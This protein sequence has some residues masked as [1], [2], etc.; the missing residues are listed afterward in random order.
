MDAM[1]YCFACRVE[2]AYQS[3]RAT[4]RKLKLDASGLDEMQVEFDLH[5]DSDN[6]R[7]IAECKGILGKLRSKEKKALERKCRYLNRF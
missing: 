2:K 4:C 7:I 3:V 1:Y 6:H 5:D